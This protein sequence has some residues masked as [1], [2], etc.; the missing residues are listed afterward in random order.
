MST[1][2]DRTTL[3]RGAGTV[4][5]AQQHFT[6]GGIQAVVETTW[7]DDAVDGYGVIDKTKGDEIVRVNFTPSGEILAA[8]LAD[9]YPY[10]ATA[11]DASLC[12]AADTAC[13]IHS[14]AGQKL[15]LHNACVTQMPN[16]TLGA[17]ETPF[18]Q[19]QITGLIKNS[20]ARSA[21]AAVYTL[22]SATFAGTYDR[23]KKIK[24]SY[25]GTWNSVTI[26]PAEAWQVEFDLTLNPVRTDDLGT[27]D[28]SLGGL[29]VRAKCRPANLSE[30]QWA[31][32]RMQN[33]A[34]AAIGSSGRIGQ[35]L[36]IAGD[37]A[38]AISVVLKDAVFAEGPLAWGENELRSG[39][40]GF[41]AVR[42]LPYAA[43]FT[44][45]ATA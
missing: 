40:I 39:E 18:G 30:A 25:T 37:I 2:F 11:I 4:K 24:A 26:T 27:I 21:A 15:T 33:D 14:F 8:L 3:V 44:I 19:M 12:G 23:T 10:G 38:G 9:M 1:S 36:T 16:L 6:K 29:E 35:D 20:T 5:L 41:V 42:P 43:L 31:Y 32:L 34:S 7:I 45:A 17:Q 22:A 13:E 28:F